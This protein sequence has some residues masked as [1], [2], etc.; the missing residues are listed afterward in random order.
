[1]TYEIYKYKGA[2]YPSKERAIISKIDDEYNP[3]LVDMQIAFATYED[4]RMF[5]EQAGFDVTFKKIMHD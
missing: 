4:A 1:M 2:T 3:F 5:I